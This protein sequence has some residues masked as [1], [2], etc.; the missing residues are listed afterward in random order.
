M[1]DLERRIY[2]VDRLR[3]NPSGVPVRGVVYFLALLAGLLA[4]SR[5]PL[6]GAVLERSRPGIC[7]TSLLPALAATVLA[8]IR[9][10]G[11]TFHQRPRARCCGTR[12]ERRRTVG[13]SRR[14]GARRWHPHD[15]LVLPDGSDARFRRLRYTGPGAVLVAVRTR[16]SGPPSANGRRAAA[17]GAIAPGADRCDLRPRADGASR[18]QV[19][20]LAVGARLRLRGDREPDDALATVRAPITFVYGNCVF[21]ERARRLLG[22]VC[23]QTSRR[24]RG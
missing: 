13:G 1:F 6:L 14:C 20:M 19:I 8:L 17:A 12:C 10:E 18:P 15:V 2:S 21:A 3:L 7:A 23:V 4:G 5:L 22:R 11:R 24:T 9:V 16:G